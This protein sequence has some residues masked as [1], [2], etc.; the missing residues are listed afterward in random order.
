MK[1]KLAEPA[2]PCIECIYRPSTNKVHAQQYY[3]P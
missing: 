3:T 1:L 2:I